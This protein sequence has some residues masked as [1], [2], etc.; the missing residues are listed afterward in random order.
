MNAKGDLIARLLSLGRG[1]PEFDVT[2]AGPA[3]ERVFRAVVR[4]GGQVLGHGEARSKREAERLAAEEALGVLDGGAPA[5][6]SG[7]GW[8]PE[9][10][11]PEAAG[12]VWPVYAAVLAQA[13]DTATEFAAEDASLDDVRRDAARLYR[14]LLA[15]LG[16]GPE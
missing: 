4:S 5:S 16:H 14:E 8:L 6:A 3:H 1:T 7:D 10:E 12:G 11:A 2:A 9:A 15:D 13:L